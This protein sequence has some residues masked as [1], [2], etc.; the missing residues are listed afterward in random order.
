LPR[1][2][3][4]TNFICSLKRSMLFPNLFYIHSDV[5]DRTGTWEMKQTSRWMDEKRT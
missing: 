2:C 5:H 3:Q 4:S 1:V